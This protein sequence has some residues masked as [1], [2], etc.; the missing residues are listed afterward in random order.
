MDRGYVR[1][2]VGAGHPLAIAG[3]VREHRLVLY[4]AIGP[5][6]HPCH[7][8]GEFVEWGNTLEVDHLNHDR[9]DNRP[10]NLRPA[11]RGCQNAHRRIGLR[12]NGGRPPEAT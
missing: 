3:W 6:T 10:D 7:H 9:Q 4:R 2:K 12:K 8:C 5:G 1:I 11:C